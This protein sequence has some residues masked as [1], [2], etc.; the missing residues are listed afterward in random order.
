M[1]IQNEYNNLDKIVEPKYKL[2]FCL[3]ELYSF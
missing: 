1:K 3:V 2:S